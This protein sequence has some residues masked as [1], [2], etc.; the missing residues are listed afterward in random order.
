MHSSCPVV[1]LVTTNMEDTTFCA[2]LLLAIFILGVWY[3]PIMIL[4]F[5][6]LMAVWGRDNIILKPRP[7]CVQG[8]IDFLSLLWQTGLKRLKVSVYL[9][10]LDYLKKTRGYLSDEI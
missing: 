5:I 8:V 6:I 7:R 9:I 2:L 4:F 1:A 3:P 10:F